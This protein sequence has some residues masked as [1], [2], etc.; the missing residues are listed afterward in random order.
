MGRLEGAKTMSNVYTRNRTAT[1]KEYYDVATALYMELRR[2]TG[3][4]EIFPKRT[5]Y[6]DV[7]PMLNSWHEMRN[8]LTKAE[9]RFPVD[10]YSLK[11]RKEYLQRAIEA[12]ETLFT[13][14]QDCVWAIDSVTPD[15]V[16]QFGLLLIQELKLLR[17]MKKNAKIQKPK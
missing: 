5:L 14:M 7:V 11:V 10:E 2:V 15:R 3:N 12:G 13:Q 1:G 17:G 16:E 9:T 6:T 8:N 4:P